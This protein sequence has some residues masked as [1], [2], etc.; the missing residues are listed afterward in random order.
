MVLGILG[1]LSGLGTGVAAGAS[2]HIVEILKKV[3]LSGLKSAAVIGAVTTIDTVVDGLFDKAT[4]AIGMNQAVDSVVDR[5]FSSVS[6]ITMGALGWTAA[7][8]LGPANPKKTGPT[9]Y[10]D[11]VLF[12]FPTRAYGA[13]LIAQGSIDALI[14]GAT[15]L[16]HGLQSVGLSSGS[17]AAEVAQLKPL[18]LPIGI[19][20]GAV[21]TLT[22]GKEPMKKIKDAWK[23]IKDH[24]YHQNIIAPAATTALAY[25]ALKGYGAPTWA[26]TAGATMAAYASISYFARG[27]HA[28]FRYMETKTAAKIAAYTIGAYL[29]YKAMPNDLFGLASTAKGYS[30]SGFKPVDYLP[31]VNAAAAFGGLALA[32]K[33]LGTLLEMGATKIKK[34]YEKMFSSPA[35]H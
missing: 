16:D 29:T 12:D 32:T 1:K 25:L 8:K 31:V 9:D 18:A 26:S 2:Y 10:I 30:P 20:L 28:I 21:G 23:Y 34:G 6:S 27:G 3:A 13:K 19:A 4:N 5:G 14:T 11:L 24:K 17:L 15:I 7:T 33:G 35:H 22:E